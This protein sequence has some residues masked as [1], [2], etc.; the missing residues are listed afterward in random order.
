PGMAPGARL[1]AIGDVYRGT[2]VAF[3]SAWRYAVFGHDPDREDDQIQVTSNSYGWSGTDNDGWDSDS[4]FIDYYVRTYSPSTVFLFSTGNG[5]PGY[6]TLAPPAPATSMGIAASTQM[7]STGW[8]SITETTQIAYGDIT[9]FSNRG[10]GADGRNGPEVAS[11]GA[12]AAGAVPINPVTTNR[13]APEDEQNGA[14]ANGTWGGTSRSSPVAAGHMALVYQA[15][16]DKNGRW[17][18]WEEARTI[19]MSGARYA[20]Y[21]T[22]TMG[23]GVV[24]GA[25]AVRIA[26]GIHGIYAEPPEW[27]PGSY[28]GERH[29]A[30]AKML[31]PGDM[32]SVTISLVNPSDHDI[33]VAL[34]GQTL[35]RVGSYDD[36]ITTRRADESEYN[37][38]AP[39]YLKEIDETKIPAGTD[40]MVVRG[41]YPMDLFDTDGDNR[42]ENN[43]RMGVYRHTDWDDDG[44][45]WD[46][47]D[48]NGVVNHVSVPEDSGITQGLDRNRGLL[49]DQGELDRYEYMR[50]SY[51]G[52]AKHVWAVSVHH[53]LERWGAGIYLGLWHRELCNSQGTCSG[54]PEDVPETEIHFQVDFYRY[55]PW[56]WLE[57][58]DNVVSVPAGGRIDVGAA[59]EVPA[60]A[61]YG[62]YQGAIFADYDRAPG[63]KAAS[64]AGWEPDWLRTVIPVVANVAAPYEWG[65]AVTF[66]GAAADDPDAPYSNG[67]TGG[68]NDWGWRPEAGDWR[69]FFLDAAQAPP[70]AQWVIRTEWQDDAERQSD[71][72]TLLYG[73]AA[74]R[75]SNPDD[76]ANTEEDWSDPAFYGPYG[77]ALKTGSPNRYLGGGRWA[78]DTSSGG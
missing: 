49:W 21:D 20:G 42:M 64:G 9:P 7:G 15:F 19:L 17:P 56:T 29:E 39:D 77:L 41:R 26:A 72:D 73:P 40:L 58:E 60:D 48:G 35:R 47:V 76:P 59:M 51:D 54:R 67:A 46:D 25:D 36:V 3:Q 27:A 62:F 37:F 66:G 78:F 5:G 31:H 74:D 61:A 10:P 63:D 14:F 57:L 18:T 6:G 28:R 55:E 69:F 16:R 65:D 23:A 12:F 2:S 4:R 45:L 70:G 1:V 53:P 44:K 8:D 75:F 52:G 34:S 24:D 68:H 50:F 43:F 38:M 13:N 71:L 32:D 22:F 33:E 30:F 11:D